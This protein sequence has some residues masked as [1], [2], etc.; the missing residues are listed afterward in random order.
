MKLRA[1]VPAVPLVVLSCGPAIKV[2]QAASGTV[3]FRIINDT[4]YQYCEFTMAEPHDPPTGLGP[5]WIEKGRALNSHSSADLRVH[6]GTYQIFAEACDRAAEAFIKRIRID[7]PTEV[8]LGG[9]RGGAPGVNHVAL[10]VE[11]LKTYGPAVGGGGGGGEPE[12]GAE[13]GGDSNEPAAAAPAGESCKGPGEETTNI[14]D[15]CSKRD[16]I[17]SSQGFSR[18][19]CCAEAGPC[20]STR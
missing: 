5:S 4:D 17:V 11:I 18:S 1:L 15:C 7:G 2:P 10:Q 19:V 3:P 14:N 20:E 6:P 16:R 9:Q 8:S 12:P 13:S